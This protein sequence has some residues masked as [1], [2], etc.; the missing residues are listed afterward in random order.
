MPRVMHQRPAFFIRTGRPQSARR[1]GRE[2]DA[3]IEADYLGA[4][5][6]R[7]GIQRAASGAPTPKLKAQPKPARQTA[8]KVRGEVRATPAMNIVPEAYR[9]SEPAAGAY[10][11]RRCLVLRSGRTSRKVLNGRKSSSS[12]LRRRVGVGGLWLWRRQSHIPTLSPQGREGADWH[13]ASLSILAGGEVRKAGSG[14][15]GFG[16]GWDAYGND[17]TLEYT[18]ESGAAQL[19]GTGGS[20]TS[21]GDAPGGERGPRMG[22]SWPLGNGRV[23]RAAV[24]PA[25]ATS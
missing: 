22:P 11:F 5:S 20:V 15:W 4:Y 8:A 6:R 12:P 24:A 18:G 23:G 10:G 14:P 1:L 25:P 16:G 9:L 2:I 13:G 7:R 3:G 21:C 17:D 19:L